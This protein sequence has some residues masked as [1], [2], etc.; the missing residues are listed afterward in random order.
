MS[1]T[2]AAPDAAYRDAQPADANDPEVRWLREVYQGDHSRQLT[3][4]AVI[5]GMLLGGIMS[6]S[7]LYIALKTG[8]SFGV[9]ITAGILA[10]VIFGVLK[11]LRVVRE[12]FGMLENNAMQSVASAAGYMTGGGTA[13]AIPALMMA[14]HTTLPWYVIF[15]W[16][17]S[18]AMM[19]VF[20]AIPMKRQMIN[21]EGLKFPSGIAAAETLRGLHPEEAEAMD[22]HKRKAM[23]QYGVT[24][25]G[26]ATLSAGGEAKPGDGARAGKALLWG[27]V[28]G[29]AVTWLREAKATWLPYPNL[30]E[31]LKFPFQLRG[32][33]AERWTVSF[34][35]SLLL[36]AAGAIMGWR[37]AW[38]MMLGA[39]VNYFFLAPYGV[40]IGAIPT[41]GY[42]AIVG[43]TVWF[44][45]SFL[46][47][48][49]LL[50]FAFSWRQVARAFAD[51]GRLLGKKTG[52]VDP[53]DSVEVPMRW[54]AFGMAAFMPLVAFF[55]WKFFGMAL[56][57][58]AL[59]IVMSFFIAVVAARATGETDTTPTG[60]LGKITQ[61]T[62]GVVAPGSVPINLMSASISAGVAIHAA[63]LLTDLKSGYLLGARP[64]QQFLAQFFGVVAGSM[65]VVYAFGLLV[66]SYEVIGT[67]AVPA[68]G[69]LA[70]H[71]V[72]R[73]LAGGVSHL[74]PSARVLI[75]VGATMGVVFVLAERYLPRW[76]RFIPSA[77]GLGLAFTLSFYSCLSMFLGACAALWLEKNR[78][79]LAEAYTVPVSSGVIAGESLIGIFI[80]VLGALHILHD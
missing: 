61:L 11:K 44:G 35:T 36:L 20:M 16:I 1:A 74:S 52:A 31:M 2:P 29:A 18:V 50:S 79:A 37:S 25:V 7:N 15:L 58:S 63:D 33:P 59:C 4:R 65:F 70:W 64:R 51:L 67:Q 21:Q 22:A 5:A 53:L 45:S 12:E 26:S 32:L 24:E 34:D 39:V 76:K 77:V 42:R 62:F 14:T 78:K 9:T 69:A 30:P 3:V 23:A 6:L 43:W 48:A 72:A 10:Y 54:F 55:A 49:G 75:G 80:K 73:V 68:P 13:A 41:V 56:W 40:S 27:G 46:L 17:T 38:S 47:T 57:M 60:A 28:A 66:P 19:G 8:W 71:S